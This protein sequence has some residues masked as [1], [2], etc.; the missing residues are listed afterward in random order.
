[1]FILLTIAM[2]ILGFRLTWGLL[3]LC[4]KILGAL[5]SLGFFIVIG[6]VAVAVFCLTK[7]FIPIILVVAAVAIL[8]GL[9]RRNG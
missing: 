2:L 9:R 3:R 4:G 1:M 6:I 8:S 5:F 7:L